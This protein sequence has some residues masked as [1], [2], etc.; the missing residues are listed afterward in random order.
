MGM[1]EYR[2]GTLGEVKPVGEAIKDLLEKVG[3]LEFTRALHI[4]TEEELTA[5]KLLHEAH[6][7]EMSKPSRERYWSELELEAK[8]ERMR[9]IVKEKNQ[10][11]S[12]LW[13]AVEQLRT[14]VHSQ[15]DG[16]ILH[17]PG[18]FGYGASTGER[19]QTKKD[20]VVFF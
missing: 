5:Q 18:R 12:A 16:R 14:H 15:H 20:N 13:D 9:Q 8:V 6:D 4:G 19:L 10:M 3:E 1:P 17:D 11:M 7:Q 2:D